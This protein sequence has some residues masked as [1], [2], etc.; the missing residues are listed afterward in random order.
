MSG[1]KTSVIPSDILVIG[2]SAFSDVATLTSIDIPNTCVLIDEYAFCGTGLNTI[3]T[4]YT[5]AY[6]N[7]V[8]AQNRQSL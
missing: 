8:A 5:E 6:T 7:L 2:N 1:C 4:E 3:S